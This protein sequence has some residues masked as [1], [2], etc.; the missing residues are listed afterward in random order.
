MYIIQF[1]QFQTCFINLP[2]GESEGR[3]G[4]V[5]AHS[6]GCRTSRG[7]RTQRPHHGRAD[8]EGHN[9]GQRVDQPHENFTRLC[10]M[11]FPGNKSK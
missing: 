10:L 5:P 8:E 6:Q 9:I 7:Q 1:L 3:G 2:S 11:P 4:D